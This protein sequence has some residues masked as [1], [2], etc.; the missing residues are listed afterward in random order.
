LDTTIV[1]SAITDFSGTSGDASVFAPGTS[2]EG[3]V[4]VFTLLLASAFL[5]E[6]GF[7]LSSSSSS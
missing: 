4:G 3:S 5:L 1:A 7:E 2:G 6:E